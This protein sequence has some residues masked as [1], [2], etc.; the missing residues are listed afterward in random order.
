MIHFDEIQIILD[1][2]KQA[3]LQQE[4]RT[5][6]DHYTTD[7]EIVSSNCPNICRGNQNLDSFYHDLFES[8]ITQITTLNI[9]EKLLSEE[10]ASVYCHFQL[11]FEGTVFQN[12]HMTLILKKKINKPKIIM[13]HISF[14]KK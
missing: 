9:N 14:L 12:I 5:L 6:K 8:K 13:H 2:V 1:K 7:T 11:Q 10:L 4:W 3:W